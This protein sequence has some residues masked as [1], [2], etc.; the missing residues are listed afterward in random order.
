MKSERQ[1]TSCSPSTYPSFIA[2]HG[3][4]L[5]SLHFSPLHPSLLLPYRFDSQPTALLSATFTMLV[6]VCHVLCRVLGFA[7]NSLLSWPSFVVKVQCDRERVVLERGGCVC[8]TN[9][10]TIECIKSEMCC[11]KWKNNCKV[12]R[13]GALT[14]TTA[15]TTTTTATT[16]SA[17]GAISTTTTT[18]ATMAAPLDK[19][20][21]IK[22]PFRSAFLV[23]VAKFT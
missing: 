16:N 21:G 3:P 5:S 9:V 10:Q 15:M 19:R 17:A 22:K 18:T 6:H 7:C 8:M 11:L 4:Q 2:L 20:V 12:T 23:V 14:T 1:A 13:E